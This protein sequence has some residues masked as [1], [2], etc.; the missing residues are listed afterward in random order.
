[1]LAST[2]ADQSYPGARWSLQYFRATIRA[3]LVALSEAQYALREVYTTLFEEDLTIQPLDCRVAADALEEIYM[4]AK[5]CCSLLRQ[6][7]LLPI[8]A[9]APRYRLLFASQIVQDQSLRLIDLCDSY[10]VLCLKPSPQG[11]RIRKNIQEVFQAVLKYISDIPR[12]ALYLEEESKS[13]EQ[14]LIAT[15][16]EK[17]A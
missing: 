16:R 10:R 8:G 13:M 14:D 15:L 6:D 1:M 17:H 7:S 3:Y 9:L 11:E 2:G 4:L 5:Q 12:Q